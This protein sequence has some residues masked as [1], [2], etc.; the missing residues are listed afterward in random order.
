[1]Q[2]PGRWLFSKGSDL[3]P[4]F[5]HPR[6][7]GILC[8]APRKI[9]AFG[10]CLRNERKDRLTQDHWNACQ[11]NLTLGFT[12]LSCVSHLSS[13][14][15]SVLN[16]KIGQKP[17]KSHRQIWLSSTGHNTKQ[18]DTWEGDAQGR[19]EA[20]RRAEYECVYVWNGRR[21]KLLIKNGADAT[22][23]Q[24]AVLQK[25]KWDPSIPLW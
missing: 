8:S 20:A 14:N 21:A 13:L 9:W 19:E 24:K 10:N 16:Q 17:R 2:P 5:S 15:L 6:I 23:N 12:L 1:M 11:K 4:S 22:E 3:V 18:A 25:S 7:P